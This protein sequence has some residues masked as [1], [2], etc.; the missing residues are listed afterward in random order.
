MVINRI[1]ACD[2]CAQLRDGPYVMSHISQ[3]AV[4][5]R[6]LCV[7]ADN[8]LY[9]LGEIPYSPY[10]LEDERAQRQSHEQEYLAALIG[11]P[12]EALLETAIELG[13]D[14]SRWGR[15]VCFAL[16]TVYLDLLARSLNQPVSEL[17]GGQKTDSVNDYF[18]ISERSIDRILG[19][20]NLAGPDRAVIQLKLGVGSLTEDVQHIRA[21]L[22]AMHTGQVLL[23]DANG[24]WSVAE[25]LDVISYF[26]DA[27]IYW[28]EPCNHYDDNIKVARQSGQPVMIDQCIAKPGVAQRAI[29]DR[30][31]E[32]ICIKPSFLGGLQVARDIRDA[33]I[34]AGI[35]IRVDGPWCGDIATA[36]FLHLAVGVPPELMIA[37]CDLREP[38]VITNSLNGVKQCSPGRIAPSSGAGLGI[39]LSSDTFGSATQVFN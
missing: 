7:R 8:G 33:C 20:L 39:K 34:E 28:E 17:L 37:G 24:G 1:E 30:I 36:A 32:A 13:Q 6:L 35:K 12:I 21:C 15:L 10:V 27:R 26:D 29:E 2:F 31:V 19:R 38:L 3:S 5:G 23:A 25:S 11:K 22:D 9:G 16:E 14:D 4:Y 18:S